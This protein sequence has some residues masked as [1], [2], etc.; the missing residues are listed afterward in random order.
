MGCPELCGLVARIVLGRLLID[1]RLLIRAAEATSDPDDDTEVFAIDWLVVEDGYVGG[2][3]A[4]LV[5]FA[6]E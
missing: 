2:V 5:R 4:E 3:G 1:A 6:T